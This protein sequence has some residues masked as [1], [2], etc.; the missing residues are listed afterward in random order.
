MLEH[1]ALP[2]RGA[3]DVE[4]EVVLSIGPV[5]AD[6]RGELGG[7]LLHTNTISWGK[8]PGRNMQSL[9]QR[10]QY[11]EPVKRLSLSV[12]YGRRHTAGS[13]LS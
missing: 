6:K 5:D 11:G 3:G 4:G 13:K 1:T 7:V 2:L 8:L 10:R 9:A 12:R